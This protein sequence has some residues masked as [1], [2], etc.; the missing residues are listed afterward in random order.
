MRVPIPT[1]LAF[2]L[3]DELDRLVLSALQPLIQLPLNLADG[4]AIE[5]LSLHSFLPDPF[6]HGNRHHATATSVLGRR[7]Y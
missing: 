4:Q 3:R 2:R 6:R 7:D 1:M 5:K